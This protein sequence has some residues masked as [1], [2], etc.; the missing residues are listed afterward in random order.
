VETVRS[1]RHE[2]V[3]F[4][5]VRGPVPHVVEAFTL[6]QQPDG[7]GTL[8]VYQG[9]IAGDLWRLGQWW[10]Q[11]VARRWEKTVATSL[12]AV[13]AEDERRAA[14]AASRRPRGRQPPPAGQ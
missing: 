4:R 6:E 9:E 7:V 13:K 11:L 5:L 8:L 1:T 14:S 3:D 10:S 2:R 12:A